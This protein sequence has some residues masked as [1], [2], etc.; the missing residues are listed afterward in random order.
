VTRALTLA[1]TSQYHPIHDDAAYARVAR[2][3]VLFGRFPIR[4]VVHLGWLASCYRPPGW[5]LTIAGI[6]E[7]TGIDVGAVRG[8]LLVLG[9]AICVLGAQIARRIAGDAAGIVA[10]LALA[11]DPLLLEAGATLESET[12]CTALVLGSLL[13]ALRARERS[14]WRLAALAGALIGAAALTRTNALALVPVIA[15]IGLPSA[16]RRRWPQAAVALGAACLVIAPWTV[17]NLVVLHHF[18]PVSTETGNT[19]AGTY[20]STSERA[21]ARWLEPSK[22][23]AYRQIYRRYRDGPTL[24]SHLVSASLDWTLEHPAYPL[25]VLAWNTTRLLGFDGPDWA[26]WSLHTM[27]LDGQPG[28][29]IWL[30]SMLITLLAGVEIVRRRAHARGLAPVAAV[31]LLSAAIVTG[32]MRLA[33]PLQ[34]VLVLLAA[35]TVADLG[36]RYGA[37]RSP[38]TV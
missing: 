18:V 16:A 14:S 34:A 22:T 13:A 7:L 36:R 31:L 4:H 10:G 23:G 5:P 35:C 26:T 24:D 12:L 30:S 15:W 37:R 17:R 8:G 32:E 1:A 25:A 21:D 33:V 19:L 29:P 2:A 28:W 9:V 3:I 38:D 11:L 6:W 27:S 20:N